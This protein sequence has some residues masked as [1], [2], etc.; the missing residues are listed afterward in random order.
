MTI[1]TKLTLQFVLLSASLSLISFLTIYILSAKNQKEEFFRRLESRAYSTAEL[2]INIES[3]DSS[4]LKTI[5]INKKDVLDFENISIYDENFEEIYTNND[6]LNF[7]QIL[8]DLPSFLFEV[9]A[10]GKQ[11]I[12]DGELS[13][14]GMKFNSKE[15]S[16]ILVACAI[17]SY[18]LGI[19][20]TMRLILV[21]VF[22][23]VLIITGLTGW[24]FAG[25][26]L[27][28]ISSVIAEV[29]KIT[30]NNLSTRLQERMNND[31]LA[32]LTQTFNNLLNRIESAFQIQK[33]FVS[34]ASH[35]LRNPLTAIT[36]QLEVALLNKRSPVE[37]EKILL[38][39][40]EDIKRLNDMSHQ[41]IQLSQ[42]ENSGTV[43]PF[44]NLR[45]DDLIWETKNELINQ[46]PE[47][48]VKL[49]LKELPEF[50]NKLIIKGNP[51]LLKICFN[52]LI[53]NACKFSPDKMVKIEIQVHSDF[54]SIKFMDNGIGISSE[55]LKHIFEPFYRAKNASEIN[56]YGIGLSITKKIVELHRGEISVVSD[57]ISG[58]TFIITLPLS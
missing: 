55:D 6:T 1:R 40:L 49:T 5:D 23:L 27:L 11:R 36:S 33:N 57:L 10:N 9:S 42:M 2:L 30:P 51:H 24:F 16:F 15:N 12:S 32:A 52:N 3:I 21:S 20:K 17:D 46:K 37:Y 54:L 44:E 31:E 13:V 7:N 25:K 29:N 26:A 38:S 22:L 45:I 28:P 8:D 19:L 35:E 34:N 47:W 41:L 48:T 14:V 50:E 58:T 43:F 39:I 56:G 18:G 53:E 4:I